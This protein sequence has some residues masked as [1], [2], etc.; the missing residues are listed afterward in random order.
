MFHHN[1]RKDRQIKNWW[2][3]PG[4]SSAGAARLG[5]KISR[6]NIW[7]LQITSC[8]LHDHLWVHDTQAGK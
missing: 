7:I 1:R 5:E 6:E 3:D 4:L 8:A 2:W